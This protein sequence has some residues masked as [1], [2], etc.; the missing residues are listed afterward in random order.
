MQES[1]LPSSFNRI[2]NIKAFES[3]VWGQIETGFRHI[4]YVTRSIIPGFPPCLSST[5]R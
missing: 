3:S 1:A 4:C 5:C 2:V